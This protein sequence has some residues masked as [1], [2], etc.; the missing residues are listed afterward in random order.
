MV[1]AVVYVA[2]GGGASVDVFVA[3]AG[4]DVAEARVARGAVSVASWLVP[5]PEN[6]PLAKKMMTSTMSNVAAPPASQ[7]TEMPRFC[8]GAAGLPVA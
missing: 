8:D 7:V 1:G 4:G 5:K 2:V 6:P 3:V